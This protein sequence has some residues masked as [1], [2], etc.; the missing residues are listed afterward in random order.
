MKLGLCGML[1]CS[2]LL[3]S[4]GNSTS[5]TSV[6]ADVSAGVA[7]DGLDTAQAA[8]IPVDISGDIPVVA[9]DAA[10][11]V[12][13]ADDLVGQK[14]S[15]QQAADSLA[16]DAGDSSGTDTADSATS[17]SDDALTTDVDA[18]IDADSATTPDGGSACAA[19]VCGDGQCTAGCET[20]GNCSKD[21]PVVCGDGACSVGE[22]PG[23]CPVDCCGSCGD[24]KCIGY[25]CAE[26]DPTSK[27]YCALDCKQPC[28]DGICDAGETPGICPQD[29][30]IK[31]CGNHTCEKGEN[32]DNCKA[33]CGANCGDFVCAGGE[34][35]DD[36]P[37]DC[38]FCGDGVCSPSPL[39]KESTATCPQDCEFSECNP[40]FKGLP[41]LQCGD[42]NPCTDDS[43]S[44]LGTCLHLPSSATC[45]DNDA[46]TTNDVCAKGS[47]QGGPA[48][49]CDDGNPCTTDSCDKTEGCMAAAEATGTQCDDGNACTK[50]DSCTGGTCAGA[51]VAC[52]DQNVC[53][54][55]SC[56]KSKGCVNAPSEPTPCNDGNAC[57]VADL[58]SGGICV[59]G[60]APD[61]NDSEACTDDSCSKATGCQHVAKADASKCSDANPCTTKDACQ[62]GKC[63]AVAVDCNDDNPCTDDACDPDLGKCTNL[64]GSATLCDDGNVCTVGDACK[65]GNCKSGPVK[66]CDDVNP[67]TTD[68]CDS[69]V[70]CTH[71]GQSG[72]A[73]D[74]NNVCTLVD[75]CNGAVCLGKAKVCDDGNVCTSDGCDP[76]TGCN[77][78][79]ASGSPCDDGNVCNKPDVCKNGACSPGPT[80]SCDD[81]NT[82]TTDSCDA[83]TGCKNVSLDKVACD[84]GSSCT[85]ADTCASGV[86]IGQPTVWQKEYSQSNGLYDIAADAAALPGGDLMVV[87]WKEVTTPLGTDRDP[88]ILRLDKTG[89]PVWTKTI[90]NQQM[91]QRMYGAAAAADGTVMVAGFR[92]G[93][94]VPYIPN[95]S[96]EQVWQL[97]NNG[98]AI[99]GYTGGSAGEQELYGIAAASDG[100]YWVVGKSDGAGMYQRVTAG[101]L[102][103]WSFIFPVVGSTVYLQQVAPV[104]GAGAL[105]LGQIDTPGQSLAIWYA[106]IS[107]DGKTYSWANKVASGGTAGYWCGGAV[108]LDGG[109]FLVAGY[110]GD[111]NVLHPLL[112]R[113]GSNGVVAWTHVL[114]DLADFTDIFPSGV[115]NE[116]IG[117]GSANGDFWQTGVSDQGNVLWSSKVVSTKP[118]GVGR[119]LLSSDGAIISTGGVFTANNSGTWDAAVRRFDAWGTGTCAIS[120]NCASKITK[121]CDDANPCT[122]DTC[123]AGTCSHANIADGLPCATAKTCAA[124]VCK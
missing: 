52:D 6:S 91:Q 85:A 86:C 80:V 100:T 49:K 82:C 81:Q 36:C 76:K 112:H 114:P 30:L 117:V 84:D 83:V 44:S 105:V 8:D 55:D 62:G 109:G 60:S 72:V 120:G 19:A 56:D 4:C 95:D 5:T 9:A 121:D 92:R 74:D 47:C 89:N 26:G 69:K 25:A 113:V 35:Y 103:G 93:I 75:T 102:L 29:C 87:G 17:G 37:V 53:T 57:T 106:R 118:P 20:Y 78:Q 58:C 67:C 12:P 45:S 27:N 70:D 43:C 13:A 15:G 122:A 71:V 32:P 41:G 10:T 97:D 1:L 64:P 24:G 14:D 94:D 59:G 123:A 50:Q 73:C 39:A 28:G 31:A 2:V 115:A 22:N 104:P 124:G 65:A 38:G 33:D 119:G 16:V 23:N 99:S 3:A 40:K 88:I 90:S 108:A 46:C 68:S 34:S 63:V 61:C 48:P 116:F 11:D 110:S 54:V 111:N 18:T 51:V 7:A 66:S 96:N 101:G 42:D 98:N 21:C 107:E 77:T 79:P